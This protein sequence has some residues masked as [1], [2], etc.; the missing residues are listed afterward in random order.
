MMATDKGLAVDCHIHIVA[1]Q[2]ELSLAEHRSYTTPPARVEDYW[3]AMSG[4]DVGRVVLVQPSCYGKDN[5]CLIG[6]L[7]AFGDRA[8][9]VAVV[10][11]ENLDDQLFSDLHDRGVRG[12]RVNLLSVRDQARP[13]EKVLPEIDAALSSS[14]WH[15]QVFLR[16]SDTPRLFDPTREYTRAPGH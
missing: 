13:M 16:C 6:A 8:R 11:P 5:S 9:G 12:V 4:T 14:N 3:A 10:D 7:G 15:I 1:H 2:S